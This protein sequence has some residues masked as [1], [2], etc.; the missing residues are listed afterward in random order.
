MVAHPKTFTLTKEQAQKDAR[1]LV[2]D[3]AGVPLGRLASQVAALLRGKHKPTFT[4]HIDSGDFVVVVNAEKVILKGRKLD[5]KKYWRHSG[6]VGGISFVGAK[7]LR[8]NNP[9]RMIELAVRRMIPK[10]ALG[11]QVIKKLKVYAGESHPHAAQ[12]PE[13]YEL[14]YLST[15]QAA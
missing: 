7:D 11:H 8:E 6:Y 14:P 12:K 2:V 3:A 5:Q 1:W 15:G 13:V 9:T 4:R 10:G